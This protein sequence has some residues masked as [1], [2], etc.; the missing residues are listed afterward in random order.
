M[1][2][3]PASGSSRNAALKPS[4]ALARTRSAVRPVDLFGQLQGLPGA[5]SGVRVP[6]QVQ[7]QLGQVRGGGG[8]LPRRAVRQRERPFVLGLGGGRAAR[9]R[10]VARPAQVRARSRPGR[11]AG[12]ASSSSRASARGARRTGGRTRR[13][14]PAVRVQLGASGRRS[15]ASSQ[16]PATSGGAPRRSRTAVRPRGPRRSPT[17]ARGRARRPAASDARAGRGRPR[18][19]RP[20]APRRTGGAAPACSAGSTS[21]VEHLGDQAC[22]SR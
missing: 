12:S 15:A 2:A 10:Q 7:Q 17:A 11:P 5:R 1:T 8:P 4:A 21:F 14:A 19:R 20:R 6:A 22:R 3:S 16:A 18:R 13:R 9:G